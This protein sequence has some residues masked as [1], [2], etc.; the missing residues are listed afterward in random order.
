MIVSGAYAKAQSGTDAFRKAW[1]IVVQSIVGKWIYD[2][3]NP[4]G[5]EKANYTIAKNIVYFSWRPVARGTITMKLP[6]KSAGDGII[7]ICADGI[8]SGK[9]IFRDMDAV[10]LHL[11]GN[12]ITVTSNYEGMTA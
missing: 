7:F 6:T 12:D 1:E 3:F 2:V 9:T 5:T 8:V 4:Y 10:S 11:T